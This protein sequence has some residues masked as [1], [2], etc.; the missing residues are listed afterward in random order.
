MLSRSATEPACDGDSIQANPGSPRSPRSPPQS[1]REGDGTSLQSPQPASLPSQSSET[2]DADRQYDEKHQEKPGKDNK[3]PRFTID[4]E[5]NLTH[6]RTT[7]DIVAVPCPGGH[8]LRSW[9][10]DGLMSRYYGA[11]SM[12]DAEVKEDADR[13]S[14]S[15]VRQ[16]IRRE[17]DR[18]RILLYEHPEFG[19]STT[20]SML[21][22]AL[23]QDLQH[24]REM[25]D[26]ERPV[27]FIG[28][29][30]GG[31]VVKMA[32]T[33]AGRDRRYESILRDCY[34]VAFF[35]K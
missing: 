1:P 25:E 3:H 10:R 33:K 28:H 6:D 19:D 29:S 16:G 12:R 18:A 5:G 26:Q 7:V 11:L 20:L 32:L 21:A 14:P 22:D 35:G 24:L 27:M 23:L 34:G 4:P 13:P 31:L 17:A 9:N 30:V 2:E 8:P 15:W